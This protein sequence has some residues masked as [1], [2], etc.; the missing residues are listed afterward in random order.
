M[1]IILIYSS[2]G[3]IPLR[4]REA[5]VPI[6]NDNECVRKINTVTEKI[7]IL[8]ASS[9]CA[10]GEEGHD[11]CQVMSNFDVLNLMVLTLTWVRFTNTQYRRFKS[12]LSVLEEVHKAKFKENKW[13]LWIWEKA[14]LV[15]VSYHY[16]LWTPSMVHSKN[17]SPWYKLIWQ[18]HL[19]EKFIPK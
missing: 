15:D 4:V 6:V 13:R 10:G 3:P 14:C 9:F 19:V 12:T 8:P 2:A 11:A 18:K 17:Y 7:F 16:T 5:S 1:T